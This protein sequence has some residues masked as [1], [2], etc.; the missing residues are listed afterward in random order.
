MAYFDKITTE[1]PASSSRLDILKQKLLQKNDWVT[2]SVTRPLKISYVS[3]EE[4]EKVGRRR[5]ITDDDR[6][7]QKAPAQRVISPE[8]YTRKRRKLDQEGNK[9]GT[10][11]DINI[12]IN[13]YRPDTA[14]LSTAAK[15]QHSQQSSES[16]LLDREERHIPLSIVKARERSRRRTQQYRAEDQSSL[17]LGSA[18]NE[19]DGTKFRASSA[20]NHQRHPMSDDIYSK[21]T[22]SRNLVSGNGYES[23]GY[24]S[25]ASEPA[26]TASTQNSPCVSRTTGRPVCNRFTID[27]QVLAER[28]GKLNISSLLRNDDRQSSISRDRSNLFSPFLP[29]QISDDMQTRLSVTDRLS[30]SSNQQSGRLPAVKHKIFRPLGTG[31]VSSES[32]D[33][34]HSPVKFFGQSP[35]DD[36]IE[37]NRTRPAVASSSDLYDRFP[38][39]GQNGPQNIYD[40]RSNELRNRSHRELATSPMAIPAPNTFLRKHRPT[41]PHKDTW[42]NNR[43]SSENN[44]HQREATPH[45]LIDD[46]TT[47]SGNKQWDQ[48]SSHEGVPE[49]YLPSYIFADTNTNRNAGSPVTHIRNEKTA[50]PQFLL[51]SSG[52]NARSCSTDRLSVLQSQPNTSSVP[53]WSPFSPGLLSMTA[54]Q[55]EPQCQDDS[56]ARFENIHAENVEKVPVFKKPFRR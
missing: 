1:H 14:L 21:Y 3:A 20:Q 29:S 25:V 16:M 52:I 41:D 30:F 39:S 36:Q 17:L 51:H 15:I 9:T 6:Q 53:R 18:D 8:F 43:F 27:D 46:A 24:S 48:S 13:S 47:I 35:Q 37:E 19:M 5:K 7:R 45:S 31:P 50:S 28:E 4:R 32:A 10:S 42:I 12:I 11:R 38:P 56:S 34:S 49:I 26:D 55:Q 23:D 54:S 33:H 44:H 2:V 22:S 40:Y